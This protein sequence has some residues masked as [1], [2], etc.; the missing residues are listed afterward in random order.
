MQSCKFYETYDEWK[1]SVLE[2]QITSKRDYLERRKSDSKLRSNPRYYKEFTEKG[3]FKSL[4]VSDKHYSNFEAWS[5]ATKS[6]G[7]TSWLDYKARYKEDP[8]LP[9][10]PK[11]KYPEYRDSYGFANV[12]LI[13]L[14]YPTYKEW[15]AAVIKLK[16][17]SWKEY[18]SNYKRDSRLYS[19]PSKRYKEFNDGG[20]FKSI[21]HYVTYEQWLKAV[22]VLGIKCALDYKKRFKRDVHLPSNPNLHY[23]EFEENGG[24][25]VLLIPDKFYKTYREWKS[26]IVL[27]DIKSW[28]DYTIRYKEDPKLFSNPTKLYPMYTELGGIGTSPRLSVTYQFYETYEEWKDASIAIGIKSCLDY[29]KRYKTDPKLHSFPA[30]I[31]KNF[32]EKGGFRNLKY[33]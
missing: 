30:K 3:G 27:L 31:Y 21:K 16:I 22:N 11:S 10:N 29:Q 12:L 17:T 7:I 33:Y 26:A 5:L 19:N 15:K 8:K 4:I 1:S 6:L 14:F 13:D 23:K 9:S 25:Q 32:T 20:G 24:F 28:K 2:L 18:Q